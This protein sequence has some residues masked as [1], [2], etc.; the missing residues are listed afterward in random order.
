MAKADK[1]GGY[2]GDK[3]GKEKTAEISPVD[4]PFFLAPLPI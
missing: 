4:P 3:A 2:L 1:N